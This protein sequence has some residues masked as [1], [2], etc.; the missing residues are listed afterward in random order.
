MEA[1]VP[2]V[3]LLDGNRDFVGNFHLCGFGH[4]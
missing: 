2:F 4:A 3:H 1:A